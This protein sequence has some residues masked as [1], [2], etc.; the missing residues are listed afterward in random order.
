MGSLLLAPLDLVVLSKYS[1]TLYASLETPPLLVQPHDCPLA[2]VSYP[3]WPLCSWTKTLPTCLECLHTVV[4]RSSSGFWMPQAIIYSSWWMC[5]LWNVSK[6]H[7]LTFWKYR[8]WLKSLPN[9]SFLTRLGLLPEFWPEYGTVSSVCQMEACPG[10]YPTLPQLLLIFCLPC[11][12]G[13]GMACALWWWVGWSHIVTLRAG[14]G[15][16]YWLSGK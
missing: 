11:C 14:D 6:S 16:P 1:F 12:W 3:F 5:F 9:D 10:W 4:S 2:W 8:H 7:Y 15:L 13:R